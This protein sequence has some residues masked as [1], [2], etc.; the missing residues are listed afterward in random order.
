ML[1]ALERGEA[2]RVTAEHERE[3]LNKQLQEAQKLEAIGTLTGRLAHDFNNLLTSI[4]GSTTLLRLECAANFTGQEHLNRIEQATTQAAKLVRQIK[5]FG[6]RS[7]AVFSNLQ[8]SLVVRESLHLLRS[9]VSKNIEFRFVNEAV[10]D[11]VNADPAQLQQ[12]MVNLVTN[13]AHAIG[14]APG[15]LTVK[16]TEVQLPDPA[17]PETHAVAS[18]DYV[19]LSVSDTG[20]GIPASVLPRIFEP[21]YTTKPV[22]SGTG[23]GLAVV[24]G[25]VTQHDGTISAESHHGRGTTVVIHLPRIGGQ[26]AVNGSIQGSIDGANSAGHAGHIL[27]VDDDLLVR[28]T[29]EAGLRHRKYRITCASGGA[30]ALKL[31]REHR[32]GF[33][34]IIT[35]QMM[36]GMT[37]IE[38]GEILAHE[39][40]GVP[41][42]LVTGFASALS[43][44][45]VKAM[46]FS[47][48]LMKPV[49]IDDLDNAVRKTQHRVPAG[50]SGTG[51]PFGS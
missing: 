16:L 35:D 45:K 28:E 37:G 26:A 15:Q 21:F 18:G 6:Q 23:M 2:A 47:A 7:P 20:S 9:T 27:L 32:G 1:G 24:H 10:N 36:P 29:L 14:E 42:I 12:V 49:T 43:E 41:L 44:A 46:G 40:P 50:P 30:Q 33:D 19:R 5:A 11:L 13:A 34:A 3:R 8:L 38:L 48:M 22:G 4:H 51:N 17:R 31:V 39:H 25:I